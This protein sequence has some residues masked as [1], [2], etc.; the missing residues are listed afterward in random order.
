MNEK[1]Y[2][3]FIL[4]EKIED[5]VRKNIEPTNQRVGEF[6][7]SILSKI[8]N[9]KIHVLNVIETNILESVYGDGQDVYILYTPD[10]FEPLFSKL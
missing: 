3:S 6:E 5:Y 10:H 4:E 1:E 2:K 9:L 7:I 8:F